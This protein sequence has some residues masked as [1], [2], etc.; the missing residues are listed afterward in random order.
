MMSLS[1]Y[2]LVWADAR[3]EVLLSAPPAQRL[4]RQKQMRVLLLIRLRQ[5]FVMLRML[6][7]QALA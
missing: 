4:T 7:K 2:L 6:L 5:A 3:C 1:N